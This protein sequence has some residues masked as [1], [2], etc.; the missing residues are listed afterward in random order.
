MTLMIVTIRW[1]RRLCEWLMSQLL[2]GFGE[3]NWCRG[4]YIMVYRG[5]SYKSTIVTS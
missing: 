5:K 1:V 3:E 2:L 4:I